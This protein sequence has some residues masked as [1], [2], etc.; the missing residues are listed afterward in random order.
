MKIEFKNGSIIE[1]IYSNGKSIRSK[2]RIYY[3]DKNTP[4]KF[5]MRG[6]YTDKDGF[7]SST[8]VLYKAW[9]DY[10]GKEIEG[11]DNRNY[12]VSEVEI[13]GDFVFITGIPV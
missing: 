7:Y 6:N 11:V 4:V 10:I 1:S 12:M 5:S 3:L 9:K 13:Q 8:E 2:P